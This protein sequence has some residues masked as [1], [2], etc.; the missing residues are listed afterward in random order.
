MDIS[1]S[2]GFSI[3]DGIPAAL[4][5]LSYVTINDAVQGVLAYGQG[6]LLV[7]VDIRS[8]LRFTL[9]TIGLAIG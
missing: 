8:A 2:E 4:C 1:S 6:A 5:S 7:K 3:N 9:M